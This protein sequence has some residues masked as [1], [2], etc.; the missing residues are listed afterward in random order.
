MGSALIERGPANPPDFNMGFVAETSKN[1]P[2]FLKNI[3]TRDEKW[4]NTTI[5]RGKDRGGTLLNLQNQSLKKHAFIQRRF[6]FQFDG[7]GRVSST[8]NCFLRIQPL[9][10]MFTA[11]N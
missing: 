6:C 1:D 10:K 11:I 5:L 3:I 8:L 7:I 4:I 2:F 9:T